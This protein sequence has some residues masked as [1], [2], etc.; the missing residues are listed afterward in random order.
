MRKLRSLRLLFQWSLMLAMVAFLG[1]PAVAENAQGNY[2]VLGAGTI[3]CGGWIAN[4]RYDPG[5]SPFVPNQQSVD[6]LNDEAWVQGN[7]TAYNRSVWK[8]QNVAS[9]TDANGM[10]AW[11]D[12]YC[13]AHPTD[14]LAGSVEALI[15][16]LSKSPHPNS[17]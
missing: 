10:Y 15:N 16:F 13:A 5:L 3:S 4:R 14:N 2:T 8:G 17:K 7:V 6:I 12:S 11:I 1:R 9:E